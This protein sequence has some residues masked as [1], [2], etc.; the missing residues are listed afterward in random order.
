MKRFGGIVFICIVLSSIVGCQSTY[1]LLRADP[2]PKT[3]FLPNEPKMKEMPPTF[4][5]RMFWIDENTDFS[6]YERIIVSPVDSS[7]TLALRGW[8]SFNEVSAFDSYKM[9]LRYL[10]GYAQS[11]FGDAFAKNSSLSWKPGKLPGD[12][13]A[14][15]DL[16]IVQLVPTKSALNAIETVAGFFIPGVGLLAIFNSGEI[17]IE[18][19]LKDA[20]TG[21][22]LCVFADREK[23]RAAVINIAGLQHYRHSENAIDEWSRK[24]P[25]IIASKNRDEIW[26]RSPIT[27]VD[28]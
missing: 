9:D 27:L 24:L 13:T 7:H 23:D 1:D 10:S 8:S 26:T 4:P 22:V 25:E 5:M 28:W 21:K 14:V 6:N 15:L 19:K 17:A 2:A 3:S 16:A 11:S 18:G 20:E 12:K